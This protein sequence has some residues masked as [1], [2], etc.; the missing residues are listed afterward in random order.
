MTR[1]LPEEERAELRQLVEE[2]LAHA[3]PVWAE[4]IRDGVREDLDERMELVGLAAES[5]EDRAE[6]RRDMEFVRDARQAFRA[7][8]GRIGGTVLSALFLA[9]AGLAGY[10]AWLKGWF[11]K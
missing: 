4:R 2:A 10:G 7:A 3:M 9:V 8:A 11:G 5:H 6:L 1:I